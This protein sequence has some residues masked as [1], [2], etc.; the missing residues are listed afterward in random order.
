MTASQSVDS[1]PQLKWHQLVV[2]TF[3][4]AA[5]VLLAKGLANM[6]LSGA[7]GI[8]ATSGYL[9]AE[10]GILIAFMAYLSNKEHR[11]SPFDAV[12]Y[13]RTLPFWMFITATLIAMVY[14]IYF[15]DF[16]NW[17]ALNAFSGTLRD[18]MG[19]WPPSWLQRPARGF[20]IDP[21][22][23]QAAIVFGY[24]LLMLAYGCASACQTLYFRGV[25]L[26]RMARFG[27]WAPFLN[28]GLFAAFHLSSPWFWPQFFI[29]TLMWGLVT[30]YTRSVWPAVMAHV[31]FNTY[32]FAWQL[33]KVLIG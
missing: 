4:P 28:T 31:I 12:L 10:A 5:L 19:F 6:I 22:Q 7:G 3:A 1:T 15:R 32:W 14:A 23:G 20:P 33:I 8:V 13:R 26:P 2:W 29:F 18:Y 16:F 27:W 21:Q 11:K 24:A 17:G 25:L 9:F 30:T